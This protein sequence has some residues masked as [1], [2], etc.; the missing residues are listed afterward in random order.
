MATS[1]NDSVYTCLVNDKKDCIFLC[2]VHC[3]AFIYA[4]QDHVCNNITQNYLFH[5]KEKT[6]GLC[7]KCFFGLFKKLLWQFSSRLIFR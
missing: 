7:K 5:Y 1:G 4:V 2:T 6:I 3:L